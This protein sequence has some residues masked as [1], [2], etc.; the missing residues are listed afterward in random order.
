VTP[1]VN[2]VY[3][4]GFMDLEQGPIIIT[5]P[6]SQGRYY[7]VEIVDTLYRSLVPCRQLGR[8][9]ESLSRALVAVMEAIQ[10]N[11]P[12]RGG[13]TPCFLTPLTQGL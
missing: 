10:S 7:M 2:N 6:D 12:D 9:I 5:T 1:N 8:W 13:T 4:F 11:L 3:G